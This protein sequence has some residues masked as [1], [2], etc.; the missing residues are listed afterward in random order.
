[1]ELCVD[2]PLIVPVTLGVCTCDSVCDIEADCDLL[3]VPVVLGVSTAL[4]DCVPLGVTEVLAVCVSVGV[5]VCDA[6]LDWLLVAVWL[7]D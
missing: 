2:A 3:G 4:R 5:N 6:E 7:S 1:M